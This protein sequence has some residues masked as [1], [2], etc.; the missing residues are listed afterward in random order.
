MQLSDLSSVLMNCPNIRMTVAGYTDN[1]GTS[2]SN[3]QLS[4]NRANNVVAYLVNKGV[5]ADRLTAEGDGDRDPIA[6]N[7]TPEGRA[8]NRRVAILVT[9]N[10]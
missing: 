3:L 8:Q 9:Q 1:V 4:R 7:L 5:S 10:R 6:D 2:D